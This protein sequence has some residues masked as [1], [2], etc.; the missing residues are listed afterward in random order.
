MINSMGTM[1]QNHTQKVSI[2]RFGCCYY[3]Q[4]CV[5]SILLKVTLL[6]VSFH[7]CFK[8]FYSWYK[9]VQR[10]TYFQLSTMAEDGYKTN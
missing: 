8:K 5:I 4:S 9:I 2:I 6:H 1:R 7:V 10:I 3:E